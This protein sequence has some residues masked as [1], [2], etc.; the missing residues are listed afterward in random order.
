MKIIKI[1]HNHTFTDILI[2]FNEICFYLRIK[3]H[4][5][6]ESGQILIHLMTTDK[7]VLSEE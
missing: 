1:F 3:R 4:L 2:L 6:I 5:F 7:N